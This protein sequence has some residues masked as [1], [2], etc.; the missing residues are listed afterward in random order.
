[1]PGT[2]E[3]E[4]A[5]LPDLHRRRADRRGIDG[6]AEGELQDPVERDVVLARLQEGDEGEAAACAAPAARASA[7]RRG[8][9]GRD[10]EER[11]T[12]RTREPVHEYPAARALPSHAWE[13]CGGDARPCAA[14]EM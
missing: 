10:E 12:R 1:M 8:E 9:H 7:A 14:T 4:G 5:A 2:G 11:R 13:G 3:A 6:L